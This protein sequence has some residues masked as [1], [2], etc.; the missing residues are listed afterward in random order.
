MSFVSYP[1]LKLLISGQMFEITVALEFFWNFK[2][3]KH[4][5]SQNEETM[6]RRLQEL[7]CGPLI[8]IGHS[9]RAKKLLGQSCPPKKNVRDMDF[10]FLLVRVRQSICDH[11]FSSSSIKLGHHKHIE[12]GTPRISS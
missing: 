9:F 10:F 7:L 5:Q 4:G 12:Q 1:H 6:Q 3:T 2:G 8:C 11:A